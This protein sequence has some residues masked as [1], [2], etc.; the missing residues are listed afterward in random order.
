MEKVNIY[1]LAK[2]CILDIQNFN[3]YFNSVYAKDNPVNI[4]EQDK[5]SLKLFCDSISNEAN[6]ISLCE[7]FYF[8]YSIAQIS[9]E[10]DLLKITKSG[11]LNI[12]LKNSFKII[13]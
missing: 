3:N 8:C 13:F 4:K 12:E 7:D 2:N 10:F 5:N 11:V 1:T 9:K 6:I